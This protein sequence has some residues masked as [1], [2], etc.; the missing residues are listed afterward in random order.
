M[1]IVIGAI[2][3][4]FLFTKIE[5]EN[6]VHIWFQKDGATCHT[7]EVTLEVLCPVFEVRILSRRADIVW[8]PRSCCL[9]PLDYYLWDS[10]KARDN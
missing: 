3:N 9:T 4:E 2:V 10:V 1:A 8:P 6:I 5:E 7:A